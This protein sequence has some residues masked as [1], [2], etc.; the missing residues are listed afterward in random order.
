M[1]AE[2]FA[3]YSF[4]ATECEDTIGILIILWKLVLINNFFFFFSV[5]IVLLCYHSLNK[6]KVK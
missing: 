2:F 4:C 6:A 3:L 5:L 1:P